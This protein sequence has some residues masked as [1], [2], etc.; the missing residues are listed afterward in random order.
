MFDFFTS[1]QMVAV[2]HKIEMV[3]VLDN[4]RL[5]RVYGGSSWQRP[6]EFSTVESGVLYMTQLTD[7]LKAMA[8]GWDRRFVVQRCSR[9]W[10]TVFLPQTRRHII[11]SGA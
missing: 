3:L 11:S 10:R 4:N 7:A 2:L 8:R 1:T 6:V 9:R 5:D